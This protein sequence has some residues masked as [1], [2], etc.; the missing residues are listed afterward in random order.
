MQLALLCVLLLVVLLPGHVI[1]EKSGPASN[2]VDDAKKRKWNFPH[3]KNED[4][5]WSS[6]DRISSDKKDE[7]R[8][9]REERR[10][11]HEESRGARRAQHAERHKEMLARR[12]RSREEHQRRREEKLKQ[13]RDKRGA[14]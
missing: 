7:R 1:A 11:R 10:K 12:E 14:S 4:G 2:D 5:T 8:N 3:E 13:R 9:A 6:A